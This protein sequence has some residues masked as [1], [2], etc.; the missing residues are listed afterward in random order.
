M[1]ARAPGRRSNKEL[2]A[3]ARRFSKRAYERN[4]GYPAFHRAV[5]ELH[6][7]GGRAVF[8]AAVALTQ[9][10]LAH[11]RSLGCQVLGQ[12]D[13]GAA[14]T[15]QECERALL[16][17]LRHE[18]VRQVRADALTS[19]GFLHHRTTYRA[20]SDAEIAAFASDT[21]SRVRGS[22]AF[23]L[24]GATSEVAVAAQLKLME[25]RVSVRARDWATTAI[26]MNVELKGQIIREALLR[27]ASDEDEIVRYEALHGL[28]RRR[29][30]CVI[31]LL[32]A[33]LERKRGRR[34]LFV[35]AASELL[36]GVEV[37]EKTPDEVVAALRSYYRRGARS[38]KS[39]AIEGG[40]LDTESAE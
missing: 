15:P 5:A 19:L 38:A 11:R 32:I 20:A 30:R 12:I 26:G 22:V 36:Y 24:A 8:D 40:V 14:P 25:D 29:D 21:D 9:D 10:A 4:N 33:E 7:R 35:S 27:R 23:A 3:L 16:T 18:R 2:F 28:S 39:R 37:G 13:S 17:V 34:H 31:P 6:A 1:S